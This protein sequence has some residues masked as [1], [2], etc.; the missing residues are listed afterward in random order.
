MK[1]LLPRT[2]KNVASQTF[3]VFKTWKVSAYRHVSYLIPG[4]G[5]T[6]I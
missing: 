3:Q 5:F 1:E 2:Q 6:G 4:E